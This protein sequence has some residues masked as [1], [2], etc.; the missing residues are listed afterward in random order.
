[1]PIYSRV[2]ND[3]K[4]LKLVSINECHNILVI[5][6]G[7]CMNESLAYDGD[8]CIYDGENESP[9]ATITELNRIKQLLCGYNNSV[10]IKYFEGDKGFL[11]M[12]NVDE[13]GDGFLCMN[14]VVESTFE[15]RKEN[16]PDIILVLSCLSGY[17]ALKER[18]PDYN[19]MCITEIKGGLSYYYKNEKGK[20][21]IVKEKSK[22]TPVG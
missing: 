16:R 18:F 7:G 22:V 13:S 21:L 9:F 6:C 14:N 12:N 1:M 8:L 17:Y 20:R 11:C 4:I 19:L 2:I 15:S 10:D 3:E 5:G